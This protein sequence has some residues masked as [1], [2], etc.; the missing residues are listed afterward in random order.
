MSGI[1]EIA[2]APHAMQIQIRE[3]RGED[4]DVLAQIEAKSFSMPWS[5]QDF[6]NL[7]KYD[8]CFYLSALADGEIV[9]CCGYTE[10]CG[11]ASID[12][13][14]VAEEYRGMGIGQRMLGELIR[15]GCE[16]HVH[17]FTLEVRV[18]NVTAIHVYEKLGFVSEG[19]R[20]GFYEKPTE[21]AM[22]MWLRK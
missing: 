4:T 5:K 13:V 11:E 22:I 21:D 12:N 8:Y 9:G 2:K 7:L 15:R 6:D 19:I 16:S 14:V 3:L 20:P 18:S 1:T 10:S 17:A